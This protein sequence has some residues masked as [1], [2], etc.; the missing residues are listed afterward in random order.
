M[1]NLTRL[2]LVVASVTP[3]AL[4]GGAFAQPLTQ[5]AVMPDYRFSGPNWVLANPTVQ[6]E[7][8][9]SAE[10]KVKVT[11]LR[12]ELNKKLQEV[13]ANIGNQLPAVRVALDRKANAVVHEAAEK[14]L[15]A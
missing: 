13:R 11:E 2:V 14:G 15:A 6:D 1:R 12:V 8:K 10:Q 7:L 3:P 5:R 4:P 9:L